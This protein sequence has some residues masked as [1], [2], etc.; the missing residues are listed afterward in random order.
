MSN[1]LEKLAAITPQRPIEEVA[2]ECEVVFADRAM[3][4]IGATVSE[5]PFHDALVYARNKKQKALFV[6]GQYFSI[7]YP[8]ARWMR[9]LRLYQQYINH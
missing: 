5:D 7:V 4:S 3:D 1:L 6:I 8:D 9:G 2:A